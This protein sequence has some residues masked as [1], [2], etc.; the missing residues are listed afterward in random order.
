MVKIKFHLVKIKFH[1]LNHQRCDYGTGRTCDY[2][3]IWSGF[4]N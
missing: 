1:V 2:N 4:P 3:N